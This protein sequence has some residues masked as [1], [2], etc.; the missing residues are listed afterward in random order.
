MKR[1]VNLLVLAASLSTGAAETI[2]HTLL[3]PDQVVR[4]PV[5][6]NR[7]TTVR[8]PSPISDLEGAYL[9]IEDAPPALFQISF[10][11]GQNFFS[12]RALATNASTTLTVGW[13]GRSYVL[14]L[15]ESPDPVLVLGLIEPL[16]RM[17]P[18]LPRA[19]TPARLR[20]LLQ[21][22]RLYSEIQAQQFSFIRDV[23]C[24]V[25]NQRTA[26][27][28]CDMLVERVFEFKADETLV[29]HVRFLNKSAE[30]IL[31]LP[32]SLGA[33]VGE[34]VFAASI[35][36]AEGIVPACGEAL[37]VFALTAGVNGVPVGLSSR[38]EFQV[39]FERI[40]TP[41]RKRCP[42][43]RVPVMIPTDIPALVHELSP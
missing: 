19:I 40:G 23:K 43:P 16:A 29:F 17:S 22:S 27:K 33:R 31:Y 30:P 24:F 6:R 25:V 7:L 42:T 3:D 36:E 4:V 20:A 39:A 10:R 35:E 11:P 26:L 13:K 37:A 14:E 21:T 32:T 41:S 38:N 2:Q 18:P 8:F 34:R 1:L 5:A 15:L 28:D 12:L 9:S